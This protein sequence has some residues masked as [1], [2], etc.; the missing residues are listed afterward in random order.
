MQNL[1]LHQQFN[2][3]KIVYNNG[4]SCECEEGWVDDPN[5]QYPDCSIDTKLVAKHKIYQSLFE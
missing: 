1:S 4:Y 5:N 3:F 2:S